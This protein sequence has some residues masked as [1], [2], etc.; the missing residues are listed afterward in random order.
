[1]KYLFF[2]PSSYSSSMLNRRRISLFPNSLTRRE[3][4]VVWINPAQQ[5][6]FYYRCWC[7]FDV[8]ERVRGNKILL[9]RH[10]ATNT[11]NIMKRPYSTSTHVTFVAPLPWS[12]GLKLKFSTHIQMRNNSR[13]MKGAISVFFFLLR[14]DI[15]ISIS[16]TTNT[17]AW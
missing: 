10:L 7:R 8:S 6:S 9:Y 15:K 17:V 14:A 16:A 2:F 12:R 1:M 13:K 5:F 4:R 11:P 3:C